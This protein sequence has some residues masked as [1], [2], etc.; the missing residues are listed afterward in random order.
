[1]LS[2]GIVAT[3][4][5]FLLSWQFAQFVLLLQTCA[6]IGTYVLGYFPR[7]VLLHVCRLHLIALAANIVLSLGAFT[8]I[9]NI[10]S[11][12]IAVYAG[13]A[14]LLTGLLLLL[15]VSTL[16]SLHLITNAGTFVTR[17][18]QGVLTLAVF[19]ALKYLSGFV[20]TD[21][22]HIFRILMAKLFNSEDFMTWLYLCGPTYRAMNF[23]DLEA[24]SQLNVFPLVLVF[25]AATVR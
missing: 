13:N 25:I 24:L 23:G 9:A 14:M 17:V 8:L 5:S 19:A 2:F 11:I 18:S 6:V 10:Y 3:T 1:M 16:I 4:L 22:G 15:L 12:F 20:V 7:N 21:D